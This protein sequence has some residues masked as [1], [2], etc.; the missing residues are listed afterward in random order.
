MSERS[1]PVAGSVRGS[2]GCPMSNK[3]SQV[4]PR[5]C[6]FLGMTQHGDLHAAFDVF[7]PSLVLGIV[8]DQHRYHSE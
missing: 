6:N 5:G 7:Y 3:G 2:G 4:G 8:T 1:C